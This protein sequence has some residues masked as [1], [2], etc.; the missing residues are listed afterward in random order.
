MKKNV[1]IG[2]LRAWLAFG[3][4]FVPAIAI[5]IFNRGYKYEDNAAVFFIV[6]LI[7]VIVGFFLLRWV[8]SAFTN[9][10]LNLSIKSILT[11]GDGS[12]PDNC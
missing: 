12:P 6:G 5:Y 2:I 1:A 3:V 9:H 10:R 7:V 11:K 8:I 4:V